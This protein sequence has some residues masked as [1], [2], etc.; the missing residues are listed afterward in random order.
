MQFLSSTN[1]LNF[2]KMSI[3]CNNYSCRLI[4]VTN[5]P[6]QELP[7]LIYSLLSLYVRM[8]NCNV[9]TANVLTKSCSVILNPIAQT[10]PMKFSVLSMKIPMPLPNVIRPIAWYRIAFVLL[11]E[12]NSQANM[13]SD[14][15]L[16]WLLLVSMVPLIKTIFPFTKTFFLKVITL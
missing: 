4:I 7:N 6:N 14:K 13:K 15:F 1:R 10:D 11:M 16:K 12:P 2:P 3:T 9:A 8:D 5:L